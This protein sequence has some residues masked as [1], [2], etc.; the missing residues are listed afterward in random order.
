[1]NLAGIPEKCPV[2]DQEARRV[3]TPLPLM[4]REKPGSITAMLDRGRKQGD[5]NANSLYAIHQAEQIG[6]AHWRKIKS[7]I[8]PGELKSLAKYKA[9]NHA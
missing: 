2:C 4:G 9:E 6:G 7:E 8:A 3:F 5:G 1:M